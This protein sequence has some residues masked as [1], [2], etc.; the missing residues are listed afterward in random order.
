MKRRFRVFISSSITH[1]KLSGHQL[2]HHSHRQLLSA[3]TVLGHIGIQIVVQGRSGI[4][5]IQVQLLVEL[6]FANRGALRLAAPAKA[7]ATPAA[8][9]TASAA[10]PLPEPRPGP[11]SVVSESGSVAG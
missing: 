11:A 9:A 3:A 6:L 2:Y 8:S 4:S 10:T 1:T 7:S 5:H